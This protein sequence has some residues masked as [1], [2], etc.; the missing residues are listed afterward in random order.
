MKKQQHKPVQHTPDLV[1]MAAH[2]GLDNWDDSTC[3]DE[4]RGAASI[5]TFPDLKQTVEDCLQCS[6][7][8]TAIDCGTWALRFY[9]GISEEN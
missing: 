9:V 6:A 8:G 5:P 3:I 1:E 2:A 7:E 4:V